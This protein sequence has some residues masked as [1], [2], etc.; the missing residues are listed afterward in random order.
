[1]ISGLGLLSM[2]RATQRAILEAAFAVLSPPGRFVQ[3][4]YGPGK[5]VAREVMKALD[6]GR[7]PRQLYVH[8]RATA[9][10]WVYARARSKR[11]ASVRV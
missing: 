6:L 7:A 8:E 11:V 4:T 3:F 9:A 1:V 5:P 10:V 2:A